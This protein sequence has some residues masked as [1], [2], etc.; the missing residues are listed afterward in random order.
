[1]SNL[2]QLSAEPR[3][4]VVICGGAVSGSEAAAYC[5]EAGIVAVVLEQNSR[6]YGKI[7]DGLPRW[8]DK[9]RQKEYA[10]IDANLSK[11]GVL[12]VPETQIGRDLG[13][14]EVTEDWGASAVLLANGA[15]R[16]RP[17][18]VEGVDDF[19]GRG[20][21]YQN[22]FVHWFNHYPEAGYDGP[23]YDIHDGTVVVGGGLASVDV[24][25]IVN[26]ELYQRALR[27]RGIEISTV[28][29]EHKGI[30]PTLAAHGIG[31]DELGIEGCTIYYRRRVQDMPIAFARDDSPEQ[32]AR[33]Q[34]VRQRMVD[35]LAEKFLVKI[36]PN[37]LP[38]ATVVEDDRLVGLVFRR[39]E[40]RDGR[41]VQLEGTDYEVRAPSTISSIGSVPERIPGIPTK[42]EL[43]HYASWD[44]GAVSGLPGVFGLGNVLTGQGNIK[45]SRSNATEIATQVCSDYLGLLEVHDDGLMDGAHAKAQGEA[46][47]VVDSAIRRA[48][49]SPQRVEAI[50][51]R[52]QARWREVGYEGDYGAWIDTHRPA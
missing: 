14:E 21:Y 11:P 24:A 52:V 6:P 18:Q 20:L 49:L 30:G 19:V 10:R 25:K 15:W 3:H 26:L 45:D 41:V 43:Y 17:L 4:V 51:E 22:P 47:R 50:L 36:E 1:M 35:I 46:Q 31:R 8:H 23:T 34:K 5:A 28:E 7:E 37:H 32:L 40:L 27:E 9:L 12:F 39:T 2:K 33:V 16:D 13:F 44:T 29:L 38:V 42:G 48:A